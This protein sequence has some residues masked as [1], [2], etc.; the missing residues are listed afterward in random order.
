MLQRA[1]DV[2]AELSETDR[3]AADRLLRAVGGEAFTRLERG[4]RLLRDGMSVRATAS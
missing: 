3:G 4:P 1:R 2:Y